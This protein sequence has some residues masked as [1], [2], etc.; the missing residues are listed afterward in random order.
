MPAKA[1]PSPSQPRSDGKAPVHCRGLPHASAGFIHGQGH[2][3]VW[4]LPKRLAV[5]TSV[6]RRPWLTLGLP[7]A[8]PVPPGGS[9]LRRG[10]LATALATDAGQ[11]RSDGSGSDGSPV[12]LGTGRCVLPWRHEGGVVLGAGACRLVCRLTR[13][14]VCVHTPNPSTRIGPCKGIPAGRV[15][16]DWSLL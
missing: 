13:S 15:S 3:A 4:T 2:G 14:D 1:V 9:D 11:V 16:H 10:G 8:I 12:L 6:A 7:V 5:S